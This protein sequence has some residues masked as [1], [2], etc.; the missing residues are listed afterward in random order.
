MRRLYA[1]LFLIAAATLL[2]ELMLTRIFDVVMWSNLAFLFVSSALFGFGLGG[3]ILLRWPLPTVR[4]QTIVLAAGCAFAGFV[5]LLIP[6]FGYASTRSAM[7]PHPT[8]AELARLGILFLFVLFPFIASGVATALL[9]TRGSKSIHK[10]YFWDL[11]GAGI[12]CLGVFVLPKLVGG[13][14]TLLVIAALGLLAAWIAQDQRRPTHYAL[15]LAALALTTLAF[16]RPNTIRFK[17]LISGKQGGDFSGA[18]FSQWDPAAKVDVLA[19]YPEL[20]DVIYD[21]GSQRTHFRAF[22]GDVDALTRSYF[23]TLPGR[24]RWNSGK[25]VALGAWLKH[26]SNRRTLVIGSGGGQETMAAL[27][28]GA[29]H[30]DAVEMVCTV[31]ELGKGR[32]AKFTGNLFTHP[33]VNVKCDEGRSFLRRSVLPYDL[34]LILSNYTNSSLSNG[35]G[36]LAPNYL[37]TTQAYRE[38]FTHLAPDG[39]IQINYVAYPRMITTAAQAWGELYPRQDFR[40]HVVIT[41]GVPLLETMLVKRN[42]WTVA[43]IDSVRSFLGPAYAD[44][45][46]YSVIYAPGQPEARNVPDIFFASP[47][48]QRLDSIL[49]YKIEPLTDDKPFFRDLRRGLKRVTPDTA[50]FVPP[51]V[52][53]LLNTTLKGPIPLESVHIYGLGGLSIAMA[54]LFLWVPLASLPKNR[55]PRRTWLPAVAYFGSLGAG[56][57]IIEL[58]LISK[59]VLL[60]GHPILSMATVLF[61]L[62]LSAAC[63]SALTQSLA[64]RF[65]SFAIVVA[66]AWVTVALLVLLAVLP[67]LEAVTLPLSPVARILVVAAVIVPVGIPL[68]MPFPL[69][70]TEL[71]HR[72]A[73]LI[74]WAWAINAFMTVVGSLLSVVLALQ[75]G[76]SRALLVAV[77]FYLVAL[78]SMRALTGQKLATS[79]AVPS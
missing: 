12:G 2:L 66:I 62:L 61:T 44:A 41:T 40:K 52:T 15:V 6:T 64:R 18:E 13:G 53:D 42:A 1:A 9:V 7:P 57:V 23:D 26:G 10:L 50:G 67:W 49:P 39:L 11:A 43:E 78:V 63:G 71:D 56:F 65:A 16:A 74:P 32:Y 14:E 70:I 68:G 59:F 20:K 24:N 22:D 73:E 75:Y 29:E 25:F 77:A 19:P 38:Y 58:V 54:A 46:A 48:D 79:P 60:I 21:Q 72:S 33:K 47:F 27:A 69:G 37:E 45:R 5:L 17:G 36:G 51:T 30:V 8:M 4:T 76:F 35:S 55:T 31:V 34:I 3:L 28:W